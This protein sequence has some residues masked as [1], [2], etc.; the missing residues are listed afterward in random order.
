M[1]RGIKRVTERGIETFWS[2]SR[3]HMKLNNRNGGVLSYHIFHTLTHKDKGGGSPN[4]RQ[5]HLGMIALGN[6][7]WEE[8]RRV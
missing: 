7:A 4:G 2:T 5:G 8:N 3:T 1:W 6:L